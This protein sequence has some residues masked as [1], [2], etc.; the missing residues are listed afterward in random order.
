VSLRSKGG[1]LDITGTHAPHC[2][3]YRRKERY[4][5]N[6]R[7]IARTYEN[8]GQHFITGDLNCP[9]GTPKRQI[10]LGHASLTLTTMTLK[11]F[12]RHNMKTRKCCP[13]FVG[14]RLRNLIHMVS[15]RS[16]RINYIPKHRCKFL[17]PTIGHSIFSQ[18]DHILVTRQKSVEKC[19]PRHEYDSLH[20]FRIGP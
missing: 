14:R 19:N 5:K 13:L 11:M 18:I 6:L 1:T 8:H 17:F 10:T 4:Y 12:R 7:E 16:G 15:E 9:Q 3:I 20:K 2:Q